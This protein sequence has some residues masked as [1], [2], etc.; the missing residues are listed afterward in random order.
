MEFRRKG[1]TGERR[2]GG[3]EGESDRQ[4]KR[5]NREGEKKEEGKGR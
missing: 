3:R 2:K 5:H 4:K 1:E